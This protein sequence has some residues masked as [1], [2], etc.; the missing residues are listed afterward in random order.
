MKGGYIQVLA[1][2]AAVVWVTAVSGATRIVLT[3]SNSAAASSNYDNRNPIYAVNGA[4]LDGDTH[5]STNANFLMWMTASVAGQT[6]FGQWFRVDLRQVTPLDHFKLWN[7]NWLHPTAATT[8]RGICDA[9][10][11]LSSLGT[12]PGTNFSDE[13]Q[14]T[15]VID[16]VTFAKGPGLDTYTGEPDVSLTGFQGRWLALRILSS[17]NGNAPEVGIS[18]L[19]VF[20]AEKPATVAES[21]TDI[22]ET[23]V[24][25]PGALTFDNAPP[26]SVFVYWGTTDGGTVSSAWDHVV[27]MGV[28]PVGA[29][30]T[31]VSVSANS[32]YFFRVQAVNVSGEGWSPAC[33][34]LTAPVTVELPARVSEGGGTV[35]VTF[36]RP[37]ATTNT[38]IRVNFSVGGSAAVGQ[39]Y[40]APATSIV[41]S[42]G[43]DMAQ[44]RIQ[45]VDDKTSEP[46]EALTVGIR[47]G[48]YMISAAST[49]RTIIMDDDGL[50]DTSAWNQHMKVTLSGY[51]GS[52]TLTNFPYA[53]R[54]SEQIRGFRFSDFA[55]PSNGG[56]LL[57]TDGATGATLPYEIETWNP[58][59]T[60]VVWVSVSKLEGTS[61]ELR[62][63]WGNSWAVLPSYTTNGVV[64]TN[65]FGGV[66]H[67]RETG[68][69]DST[70]NT[71]HG[72]AFGN[73]TAPGLLGLGQS[74][75][76]ATYI[77]VPD[78]A[79]IGT[80][81]NGGL[82]LSMWLKSGVMLTKTNESWRMLEKGDVYYFVQGFNNA[83]GLV[84]IL[85]QTNV[86]YAVGN[87][88]DIAPNE[89]HYACGTFDGANM[90]LYMDGA[91]QGSLPLAGIIDDDK[92]PLRIGSD[93]SGKFFTG[94]IDETRVESVPRSADWVKAC[95]DSQRENATLGVFGP[96]THTAFKG[97]CIT[98]Y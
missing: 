20:A 2:F 79:S 57:V 26:S 29:F 39:D 27:A 4:G 25:L 8:N 66:W 83:G 48:A 59:G 19:Q 37:A 54:L 84:F 71:N 6:A 91:P 41:I 22:K 69:R 44:T 68:A 85:K 33:G 34:F 16:K 17:Y 74:F 97:T 78:Q 45:L 42:A 47:P 5:T 62:L 21:P 94:V 81:V 11:Y 98:L 86:V 24:T 87:G 89:W 92:L 3:N 75:N 65:G 1:A 60:S 35:P 96:V 88:A 56:D 32:G 10:V 38:A 9:E 82:T 90:R 50:F 67:M 70:S 49:N 18:E 46:D 77:Q 51:S 15:R 73:V 40:V 23:R 31:N 63:H 12:T 14:W 7:F 53:L 95:Y 30:S 43:A 76:G 80:N 72:T 36:R 52:S 64:W 58:S 55:S 28:R 13:T 93:D 61:T